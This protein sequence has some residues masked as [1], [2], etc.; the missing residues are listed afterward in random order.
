MKKSFRKYIRIHNKG[1]DMKIKQI[2]LCSA[3]VVFILSNA[4]FA[5]PLL[6]PPPPSVNIQIGAPPAPERVV[7]RER[8]VVKEKRDNGKHKGHYKNKKNKKHGHD[9]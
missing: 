7:V 2:V 1:E 6:P 3:V 9:E 5:G 4:V 8:V